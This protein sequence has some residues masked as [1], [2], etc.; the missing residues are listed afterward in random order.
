LPILAFACWLTSNVASAEEFEKAL[1]EKA[2]DIVKYLKEKKYSNVGVLKFRTK[3]GEEQPGDNAGPLN[4]TLA[5]RLEI[6]LVL[7]NDLKEPVGVLRNASA[8]A[9]KIKGANHLTAEGRKALFQTRYPIAWGDTDADADAFLTGVALVDSKT[10]TI[11]VSVQ[12]FD[13]TSTKLEQVALVKSKVNLTDLMDSGGSFLLRGAFDD[14][15]PKLTLPDAGQQVVKTAARVRAKEETFPLDDPKAPVALEIRYD[16]K[17]VRVEFR[18]G[19]GFVPE[20]QEG[21][22][23]ILVVRR[24]DRSPARL[25]VVLR[26]NGEN[27][28]YKDRLPPAQAHMWVMSPDS[29]PLEVE[30]F[31]TGKDSGEAFRILSPAES[32]RQEMNY[33]A[34]V[35]TISLTVFHEGKAGAPDLAED[36]DIAAITRGVFP[37]DR[38]RN[39]SALRAQLRADAAKSDTR[40]LIV[41]G[42]AIKIETR[43]VK[44]EPYP[45]PIL[46]AT[47][48]YY[49]R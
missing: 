18:D 21:Q 33:G 38:A 3:L 34:D 17:P 20:P 45:V 6:A 9:A 16:G 23:V 12:A 43:K 49:H 48:H 46:A 27:T 5:E 19:K 13:R 2:P 11:T 10:D 40:G 35:G 42:D 24:K 29:D 22:K 37:T 41:G 36:E 1:R 30:G 14:G 26:V 28:L 8:R 47:I 7:A 31:K 44:F 32:K 15:K 39:L 4:R 25:G